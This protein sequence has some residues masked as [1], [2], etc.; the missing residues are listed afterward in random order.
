MTHNN[1]M[2]STEPHCHHQ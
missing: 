1:I 2:N